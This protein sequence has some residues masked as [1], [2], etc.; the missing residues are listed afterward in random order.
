[1]YEQL[2]TFLTFSLTVFCFL[3]MLISSVALYFAIR[4][5]IYINRIHELSENIDDN[6]A[7]ILR[8]QRN[9]YYKSREK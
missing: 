5:A 6:I 9:D 8:E 1:M 2:S 4:T 7:N 3:P